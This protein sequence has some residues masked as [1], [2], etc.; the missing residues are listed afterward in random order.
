MYCCDV[1]IL[2]CLLI[3][4][5]EKSL[6]T[7]KSEGNP[8]FPSIFAVSLFTIVLSNI[9]AIYTTNPKLFNAC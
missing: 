4:W 9:L 5:R 7:I 1:S 8:V 6:S 2:P 3:S